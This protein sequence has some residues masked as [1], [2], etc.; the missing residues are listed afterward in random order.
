[1]SGGPRPV[2]VYVDAA[3]CGHIGAHMFAGGQE[4]VFSSHGPGWL[5]DVETG[6]YDREIAARFFGLSLGAELFP[7]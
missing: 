6:I 5:S 2:V 7:G 1:M 4:F 3:G